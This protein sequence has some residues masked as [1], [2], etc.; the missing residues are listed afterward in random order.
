MLILNSFH[1][2]TTEEVNKILKIR[3]M[4]QVIIPGGMA[5][6]LE[7][8]D[9]CINRLFKAMLKGQY[10][11]WMVAGEHE[12]M[13]MGKIK[14]PDVEQLCEWIREAWARISPALIERVL[15]SVAS[16]TQARWHGG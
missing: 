10:T 5:L 4:D 13:T 3:N 9:V 1:G 7:L 6:L 15:S 16:P 12:F 11:R 2:H 8:L 14:R